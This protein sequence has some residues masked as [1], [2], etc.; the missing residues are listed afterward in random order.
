MPKEPETDAERVLFVLDRFG[1]LSDYGILHAARA[2]G[3]KMT[4]SSARSRRAEL[5]RTGAIKAVGFEQSPTGRKARTWGFPP[6]T[7]VT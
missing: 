7:V 3:I 5:T 4:P 1:P 2:V 6:T